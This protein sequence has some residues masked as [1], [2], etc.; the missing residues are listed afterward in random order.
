MILSLICGSRKTQEQASLKTNTMKKFVPALVVIF[1]FSIAFTY[2]QTEKGRVMIGASS[3]LLLDGSGSDIMSFGFQNTKTKSDADN[4]E[5]PDP[6]KTFGI[7]F[8]P[9]I[10]FFPIDKLAVGLEINTAYQKTEYGESNSEYK[11]SMFAL[12][13]FVR[14]YIQT[15]SVLP[16]FEVGAVFGQARDKYS[17]QGETDTYKVNVLVLG[18]GAGLAIPIGNKLTFDIMAGYHSM[19]LTPKENNDDNYRDVIGTLGFKFGF[20]V[21]PGKE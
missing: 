17:S 7:N 12:G 8:M 10:G 19:K 20:L 13:P 4:F 14:Y 2:A 21:F 5:E 6:D 3:A 11:I 9:K 16:F 15:P 18:G 1:L